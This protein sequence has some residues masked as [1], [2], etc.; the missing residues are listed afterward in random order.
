MFEALFRG[1]QHNAR[2]RGAKFAVF[3]GFSRVPAALSGLVQ[4]AATTHRVR[5]CNI[6]CATSSQP[7]DSSQCHESSGGRWGC[8]HVTSSSGGTK[9]LGKAILSTKPGTYQKFSH[10]A[11]GGAP[12]DAGWQVPSFGKGTEDCSKSV[13]EE[14]KYVTAHMVQAVG[15]H[16]AP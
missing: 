9:Q 6:A 1:E 4:H 3:R 11:G 2:R 15:G 13:Y 7:Q 12:G 16:T 14:V 10:L 8:R 5:R